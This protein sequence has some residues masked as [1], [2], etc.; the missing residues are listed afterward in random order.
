MLSSSHISL[1]K[2][3]NFRKVPLRAYQNLL[4]LVPTPIRKAVTVLTLGGFVPC[5]C[6]MTA[7]FF[8]SPTNFGIKLE[9]G[10]LRN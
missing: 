5:N 8:S 4:N 7:L 2:A 9:G 1:L 6:T 3:L 10:D